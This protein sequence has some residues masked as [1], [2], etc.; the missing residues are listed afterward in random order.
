MY[1]NK[2]GNLDGLCYKFKNMIVDP[3]TTSGEL[4]LGILFYILSKAFYS[5]VTNT[6][7]YV[8]LEL[9]DFYVCQSAETLYQPAWARR[10]TDYPNRC[11]SVYFKDIEYYKNGGVAFCPYIHDYRTHIDQLLIFRPPYPSALHRLP[12]VR[13]YC[14]AVTRSY[15][16]V[17]LVLH[18][19]ALLNSEN[20]FA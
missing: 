19:F 1:S 9:I 2:R 3:T 4:S 18:D 10:I 20:Y 12:E 17:I 14:V 7:C 5:I 13:D 15:F 11:H 8:S 16:H 6:K